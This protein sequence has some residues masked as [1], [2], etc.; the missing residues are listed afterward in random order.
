MRKYAAKV[1]DGT[2]TEVIVGDQAWASERLGGFWVGSDVKVGIGWLYENGHIV[3]PPAPEPEF[4][5]DLL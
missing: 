2:V 4:T 5:G 1:E 3:P